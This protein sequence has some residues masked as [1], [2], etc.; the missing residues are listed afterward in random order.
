MIQGSGKVSKESCKGNTSKNNYHLSSI[1]LGGLPIL[2]GILLP[3][4]N[5]QKGLESKI[6]IF[7]AGNILP[8]SYTHV[9]MSGM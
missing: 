2:N 1:M 4:L 7:N 3:L 8:S 9:F 5:Q 6:I